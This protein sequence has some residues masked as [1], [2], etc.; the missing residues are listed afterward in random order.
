MKDI[1]IFEEGT[2]NKKY[3]VKIY[4]GKNKKLKKT[5][6]F[7]DKRYEQYKDKTPLG[8]YSN[9]DH[10]DINR[11]KKY[12]ARASKIKNKEGKLTYKIK[13]S[14]NFFSYNYLW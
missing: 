8:L 1:L 9:K 14:P 5:V 2:G 11:R 7:G 10:N 3:K 6:Q 13:Y 12:R 4:D